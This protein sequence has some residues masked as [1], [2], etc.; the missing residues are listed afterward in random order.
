MV[1]RLRRLW[2][3][4]KAHDIAEYAVMLAVI[5]WLL[6]AIDAAD[7]RRPMQFVV[8]VA[9]YDSHWQ[10]L[11]LPLEL[12]C[13]ARYRRER[14]RRKEHHDSHGSP[15]FSYALLFKKRFGWT[16]NT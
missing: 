2:L 11:S 7:P 15:L 4:E 12:R 1:A 6:G 16:G 14:H 5:P 9:R 8:I 13:L 3:E 10:M